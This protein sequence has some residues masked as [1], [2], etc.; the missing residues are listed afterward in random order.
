MKFFK[1]LIQFL[2]N[3]AN[4]VRIPPK[5]KK[6]LLA[7]IAL[8]VSPIDLIPDWLPI[9]GQLDDFVLICIIADYFFSVLDQEVLLSHYPWG[10][11]SFIKTKRTA[12]FLSLFVPRTFKRKIWSYVGSPY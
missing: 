7:M 5:D 4:D 2:Q 3:V 12:K 11:K 10:M 6:I 9:V 8:I 1:D